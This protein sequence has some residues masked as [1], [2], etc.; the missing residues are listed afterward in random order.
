MPK[1]DK[2]KKKNFLLGFITGKRLYKVKGG[3]V[4]GTDSR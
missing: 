4:N 2:K 1:K 3:L